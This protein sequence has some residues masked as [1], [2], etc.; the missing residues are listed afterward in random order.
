MRT[1]KEIND[2][3]NGKDSTPE[4]VK[5]ASTD[6]VDYVVKNLGDVLSESVAIRHLR[7]I[8]TPNVA[9]AGVVTKDIKNYLSKAREKEGYGDFIDSQKKDIQPEELYSMI[10]GKEED[11]LKSPSLVLGTAAAAAVATSFAAAGI[12][13]ATGA[14]VTN[15]SDATKEPKE[16]QKT[17]TEL[18]TKFLKKHNLGNHI[19]E[20]E[21]GNLV[22][23]VEKIPKRHLLELANEKNPDITSSHLEKAKISKGDSKSA[24]PVR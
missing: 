16:N 14:S 21:K 23:H 17:N 5:Q 2:V 7:V 8:N 15:I 6:Y 4:Q 12:I 9:I 24:A 10:A 11:K 20:N 1:I 3:R 18:V 19:T 13:M 22:I